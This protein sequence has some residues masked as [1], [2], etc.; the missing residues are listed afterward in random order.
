MQNTVAKKPFL[1]RISDSLTAPL[2]GGRITPLLLLLVDVAVV[3]LTYGLFIR[4][5]Y[6]IDSYRYINNP[7]RNVYFYSAAGRPVSAVI[8]LAMEALHLHSV[9][10]QPLFTYLLMMAVV[11]CVWKL[12]LWMLKE[13]KNLSPLHV[14]IVQAVLLLSLVNVYFVDWFM[15]TECSV[16]MFFA[17]LFTLGAIRCFFMKNQVLGLLSSFFF[18]LLATN[19]YQVYFQYFAVFAFT[20]ILLRQGFVVN[21]KTIFL[22]AKVLLLIVA[23]IAATLL[24]SKIISLHIDAMNPRSAT[25]S[26][27]RILRNLQ[28]I[29]KY[30]R[31][32]WVISFDLLPKYSTFI[33]FLIPAALLGMIG[34]R[35]H[36]EHLP[37]VLFTL[38]L[39][40]VCYV[41][42]FSPHIVAG[43]LW[44]AERIFPAFFSLFSLLAIAAMIMGNRVWINRFIAILSCCFLALNIWSVQ[45][46]AVDQFITNALDKV[47]CQQVVRV[48]T[49]YEEEQGVPVT[50]IATAVDADPNAYYGNYIEFYTH[51]TNISTRSLSF[52]LPYA[53]EFYAGSS[54]AIVDMPPDIYAAHFEGKDWNAFDPAQVYI[55]GDTVYLCSY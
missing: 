23:T 20:L 33:A 40:G 34:L 1:K 22:C 24:I 3:L 12:S 25:S 55:E 10:S 47:Y 42:L 9:F 5:H 19:T 30:Q 21:R 39:L 18:L 45:N 48:I 36:R 37:G 53:V 46:I 49:A 15:F 16:V 44:L 11:I 38:V 27:S 41:L 35:N 2:A 29:L 52:S 6:S 17:L 4:D 28:G 31:V 43:D 32:F 50:K 26:M 54:L 14:W 8:M 13:I 7:H 51:D